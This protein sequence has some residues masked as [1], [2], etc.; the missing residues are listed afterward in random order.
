MP[1]FEYKCQ[2]CKKTYE[3]YHKVREIADDNRC[4][5]CGSPRYKKLM[6]AATVSMGQSASSARPETCEGCSG[7][8]C[9]LN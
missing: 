1:V 9:G 3:V 2:D 7:E 4:P 8:G 5:A 6:S